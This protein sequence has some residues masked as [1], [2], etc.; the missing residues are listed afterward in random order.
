MSQLWYVNE[1]DNKISQIDDQIS[2]LNNNIENLRNQVEGLNEEATDYDEKLS[3]LN[4]NLNKANAQLKNLKKQKERVMRDRFIPIKFIKDDEITEYGLESKIIKKGDLLTIS[5]GEVFVH[6]SRD[7]RFRKKKNND[8]LVLSACNYEGSKKNVL[9]HYYEENR[10]IGYLPEKFADK[11]FVSKLEEKDEL[12]IL[13]FLGDLDDLDL[14]K[15]EKTIKVVKMGA[16]AATKIFS[17]IGPAINMGVNIAGAG[18]K[19]VGGWCQI[20]NILKVPIAFKLVDEGSKPPLIEGS[21][22]ITSEGVDLHEKHYTLDK[23]KKLKVDNNNPNFSYIK[24]DMHKNLI[25]S[26][27]AHPAIEY[28]YGE[29]MQ[30]IINQIDN[31]IVLNEESVESGIEDLLKQAF[32]GMAKITL[33][34]N[35]KVLSKEKDNLVDKEIE[36]DKEI[37]DLDSSASDYG[38][39]LEKLKAQKKALVKDLNNIKNRMTQIDAQVIDLI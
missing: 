35:R 29:N 16:T 26:V 9:V 20:N 5:M 25:G 2:T 37:D 38:N 17:T 32:E 31:S 1:I 6:T 36:I 22:I 11:I 18:I 21:Y 12:E 27:V 24:L 3:N 39:Q 15:L 14:K 30:D 19:L 10:D 13:L 7:R 8:I 33:L 34:K 4:N 28:L 23:F